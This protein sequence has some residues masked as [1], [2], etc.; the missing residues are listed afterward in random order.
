[1]PT[2][3]EAIRKILRERPGL[4][5]AL[6]KA[7]EEGRLTSTADMPEEGEEFVFV[8]GPDHGGVEGSKQVKCECGAAVWMSPSTQLVLKEREAFPTRILCPVCVMKE[9]VK[10]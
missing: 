10:P 3:R 4:H 5:R 9:Y 7:I 2:E 8:C 1:M 6:A